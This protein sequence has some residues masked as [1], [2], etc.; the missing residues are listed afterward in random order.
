MTKAQ[1]NLEGLTSKE[2]HAAA[3]YDKA[4]AETRKAWKDGE[5]PAEHR[6]ENEWADFV[7]AT[8]PVHVC[9]SHWNPTV[10]TVFTFGA[11]GTTYVAVGHE[12]GLTSLENCLEAAAERLLEVAPGCFT[13]P[14]Y[15]GVRDSMALEF[16]DECNR[17]ASRLFCSYFSDLSAGQKSDVYAYLGRSEVSDDDVYEYVTRDMTYTESGFIPSWEWTIVGENMS[18]ADVLA[19]ASR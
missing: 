6:A 14:D 19:L 13:E 8:G 12:P 15:E 16:S 1:T 4:D 2:W 10:F 17:V 7:D 9:G 3:G 18:R 5:C 11:Y